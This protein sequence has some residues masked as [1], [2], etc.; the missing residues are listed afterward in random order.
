VLYCAPLFHTYAEFSNYFNSTAI[1]Q[2]VQWIHVKGMQMVRGTKHHCITF[3]RIDPPWFHSE[4]AYGKSSSSEELISEINRRVTRDPVELN[5]AYLKQLWTTLNG[6]ISLETDHG[7]GEEGPE[8]MEFDRN[9]LAELSRA[10]E[11]VIRGY[12][13]AEWIVFAKTASD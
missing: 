13:G 1:L 4:P 9:D 8:N 6:I 10:I 7:E 12:F 5:L 2:N 11:T 3:S